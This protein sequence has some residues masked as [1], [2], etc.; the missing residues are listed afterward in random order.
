MRTGAPIDPVPYSLSEGSAADKD[1]ARKISTKGRRSLDA[2][3]GAQRSAEPPDIEIDLL[4]EEEDH[5]DKHHCLNEEQEF[6]DG[7]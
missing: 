5:I 1:F 2:R 4:S 6:E 3:P 7:Y